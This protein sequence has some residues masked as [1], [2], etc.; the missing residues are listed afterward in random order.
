MIN[1]YFVS[2]LGEYYDAISD[3]VEKIK[4]VSNN[5]RE[6]KL[7]FRGHKIRKYG[8]MPTLLRETYQDCNGK[9]TYGEMN[10]MED[11]RYQ[12]F[13]SRVYHEIDTSPEL[14]SE[15][16]E[17]YQHNRG[18]TRMLDWSESAKTALSFSVEPYITTRIDKELE[19]ERNI[20]TPCVWVVSP[21]KLNNEVYKFFQ[22]CDQ[23]LY[24]SALADIGL[25]S[26]ARQIQNEIKNSRGKKI[27]FSD[28]K[29]DVEIDGILGLGILEKYR[30]TMGKR[31]PYCV[32]NFEFNPFHYMILRFYS[33][34]LPIEIKGKK[35]ILPPLAILEPYHTKRIQVQR[36]VFTVFPNYYINDSLKYL[37]K[38]YGIDYR[39]MDSQKEIQDCMN[40]INLVNPHKIAKQLINSGQRETELYPDIERYVNLIETKQYYY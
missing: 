24:K 31:L 8:L 29:S 20:S 39:P 36:G 16:Q 40:K 19:D 3:I 12:H 28:E 27:Y 30:E 25:Q 32:E 18:K 26:K 37:T 22:N 38:K 4:K 9:K 5:E 11:Y 23:K 15:W 7:W 21:F 14:R 17:I 2:S 6:P 35:N 1:E 34:A 33:D 10:R 13:K